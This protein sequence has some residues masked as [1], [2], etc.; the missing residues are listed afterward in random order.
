[1]GGRLQGKGPAGKSVQWTLI[2]APPAWGRQTKEGACFAFFY[3]S[4][5]HHTPVAQSEIRE[6]SKREAS[7]AQLFPPAPCR[8]LGAGWERKA[9]TPFSDPKQKELGPSYSHHKRQSLGTLVPL[10]NLPQVPC[11]RMGSVFRILRFNG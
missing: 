1:M 2:A 7:L 9:D 4:V 6:C 11:H 5:E 8:L 10:A 3:C